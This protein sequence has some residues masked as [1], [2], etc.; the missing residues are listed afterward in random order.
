[1]FAE[2]QS[3][4]FVKATEGLT[5]PDDPTMATNVANAAQAGLLVGVYHFAHPENLTAMNGAVQEADHLLSDAGDAI[6]PGKL[7][8]VLDIETEK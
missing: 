2:G 3:F 5:G 8:P 7:R 4:T 6:G 1:M